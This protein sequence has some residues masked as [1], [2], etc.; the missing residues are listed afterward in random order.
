MAIV[1]IALA[2]GALFAS[3]GSLEGR[4]PDTMISQQAA[5]IGA[6]YMEEVSSKAFVDPSLPANSP[7]CAGTVEP[8]ANMNNICDYN[9]LTDVG[10]RDQFNNPLPSLSNYTVSV[11]VTAN[12]AWQGIA[13]NN[14]VRIDITVLHVPTNTRFLFTGIR[15]RY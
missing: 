15:T 2:A 5:S 6:S 7:A 11:R 14:V 10:A 3:L 12:Y 9:N 1:I 4:G 8:R 13:P